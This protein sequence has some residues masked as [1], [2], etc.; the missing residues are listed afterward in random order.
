MKRLLQL[1]RESGEER[2]HRA[3]SR[4]P[5]EHLQLQQQPQPAG[6]RSLRPRS[7]R[8]RSAET[9][10]KVKGGGKLR[11]CA[12][13]ARDGMGQGLERERERGATAIKRREI[14]GRSIC[15]C[16]LLLCSHADAEEADGLSSLNPHSLSLLPVHCSKVHGRGL[17]NPECSAGTGRDSRTEAGNRKAPAPS[18][19]SSQISPSVPYPFALTTKV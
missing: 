14:R 17:Q 16:C 4:A 10:G 11:G 12:D 1:Q 8:G 13:L 9:G 6:R 3:R 7:R 15:L 19:S 18:C 5:L 2:E